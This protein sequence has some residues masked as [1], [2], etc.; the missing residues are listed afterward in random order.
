M[1]HRLRRRRLGVRPGVRFALLR[2]QVNSRLWSAP[3]Q[4]LRRWAEQM[5]NLLQ[6]PATGR[7]AEI[8]NGPATGRLSRQ[9][10]CPHLLECSHPKWRIDLVAQPSQLGLAGAR[11]AG[12]EARNLAEDH[13]SGSDWKPA[14]Q[15]G[16]PYLRSKSRGIR[17]THR[18]FCVANSFRA[19]LLQRK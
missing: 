18:P 5:G 13:V 17:P 8:R 11:A 14:A 7:A 1:S 2:L 4:G 16:T 6:C 12:G 3:D 10:R 9:I 15:A 19:Y